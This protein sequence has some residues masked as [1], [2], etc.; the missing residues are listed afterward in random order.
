MPEFVRRGYCRVFIFPDPA[1]PTGIWGYYT[2]S[3]SEWRPQDL[4][5]TQQRRAIGG[6]P[7]PM[8]HIGFIGRDDNARK[9]L[10]GALLIDAARRVYRGQI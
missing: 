8:A 2:L 4:T 5:S 6:I 3:P 10:G 1:D 7:V 9:G